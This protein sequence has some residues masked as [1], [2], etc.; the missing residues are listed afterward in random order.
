M[1][2]EQI[3]LLGNKHGR[4]SLLLSHEA[5]LDLA[6]VNEQA[7]DLLVELAARSCNV[8]AKIIQQ[9]FDKILANK[10][11]LLHISDIIFIL[12]WVGDPSDVKHE[13]IQH[14]Q[15]RGKVLMH[16]RHH[17][18]LRQLLFEYIARSPSER[19]RGLEDKRNR[20]ACAGRSCCELIW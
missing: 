5:M 15:N 17:L 9:N 1:L 13:M 12:S 20:A 8:L 2:L 7:G 10:V 16:L 18:F 3:L 4:L 11:E 6:R 19:G 14:L